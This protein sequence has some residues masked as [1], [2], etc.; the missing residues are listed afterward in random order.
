MLKSV[1]FDATPPHGQALP[2]VGPSPSGSIP[3]V[4][5]VR[6]TTRGKWRERRNAKR[7]L[8]NTVEKTGAGLTRKVTPDDIKFLEQDFAQ[9]KGSNFKCKLKAGQ[10]FSISTRYESHPGLEREEEVEVCWNVQLT[11][12]QVEKLPDREHYFE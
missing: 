6:Q 10:V 11:R 8:V 9:W 12:K 4:V 7:V 5:C 1:T 3:E 2:G